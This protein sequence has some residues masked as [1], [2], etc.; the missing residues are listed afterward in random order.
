MDSSHE[1]R[2]CSFEQDLLW[3][4]LDQDSV[5][6]ISQMARDHWGIDAADAWASLRRHAALDRLR[7][8]IVGAAPSV[9][10]DLSQ[11][12]LEDAGRDYELF[13]APTAATFAR[14]NEISAET[15]VAKQHSSDLPAVRSI[16]AD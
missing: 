14:L 7:A 1:T 2:A 3:S 5:P 8:N 4:V 10:A 13:V 9:T 6:H 15:V 16:T 11:L 12:S